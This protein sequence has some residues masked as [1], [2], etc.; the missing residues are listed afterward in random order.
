LMMGGTLPVL[1]RWWTGSDRGSGRAVSSLYGINTLGAVCGVGLAGFYLIPVHGLLA[2]LFIA[3]TANFALAL[4]AVILAWFTGRH[5]IAPPPD[6]SPLRLP[7]LAAGSVLAASLLMGLTSIADEVFW[8]RIFVLHIGSSVYAYSLML[9]A[10]L[11]GIGLGSALTYRFIARLRVAR[12]LGWLELALGLLLAAQI[13]WFANF[14]D[15]LGALASAFAPSSYPGTVL[16]LSLAVFSAVLLPTMIMGATFPLTVRLYEDSSERRESAAVGTVYLA[17]TIGSISGSLLAGFVL[18]PWIGSQNGLLLMAAINLGLGMIFLLRDTAS[19]DSRMRRA[20]PVIAIVAA[21]AFLALALSARPDSVILG[22]GIF[23][24]EDTEVLLFRED[25]SATVTLRRIGPGLSLE[26]NG[27]NV[28]GTSPSLLGTQ[29]LQAHLPLLMHPDP[30]RILHIGFGSGGTAWSVSRHPVE[31]ITIAEISPEVLEVS[32]QA[33]TEVNHGV[34]EDPRVHVEIN[35]GRNFILTT[36]ETFDVILSDSIHPRYA[37]NGSLYT[38]DYFRLCR[39]RLRPGGVVSMWL[40]MYSLTPENF[41]MILRAFQEVFPN[42]TVWYV[43]TQ[44]NAFTIVIGRMESERMSLSVMAERIDGEIERDLAEIGLD[45]RTALASTLM[46]DALATARLTRDTAPHVDDRPAI[47]YE[48][49]RITVDRNRTWLA[50]FAAIARNAAP[51]ERAFEAEEADLL[52][53]ERRRR[54]RVEDHLRR[55]VTRVQEPR[56]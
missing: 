36:P 32:G 5:A 37:G 41:R 7:S 12:A 50:N 39:Q 1:V 18:I 56:S 49:G 4:A 34:L 43:P 21:A 14:A 16:L 31:S 20:L 44:L 45:D 35:D 54:Q 17:N 13:H 2:T 27:V 6:P 29:K 19:E 22:A 3:V 15:V 11:T 24:R 53:A 33:L 10:F 42:T 25:V 48:S 38:L 47:E 28:A 23:E 26:L 55:L 52:N 30:K 51:L 40:P 9:F 8:S 46:L